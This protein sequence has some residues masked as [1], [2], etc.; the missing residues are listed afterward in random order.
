MLMSPQIVETALADATHRVPLAHAA[1][2][3]IQDGNITIACLNVEETDRFYLASLS[4]ALVAQVI[5]AGIHRFGINLDQPLN[6]I[7]PE[8]RLKGGP[9]TFDRLLN[10]A[11]GLTEGGASNF[12]LSDTLPT[13]ERLIRMA[14]AQQNADGPFAFSYHNGAYV[15]ACLAFERIAGQAAEK[16]I[17]AILSESAGIDNISVIGGDDFIDI[18]PTVQAGDQFLHVP[19]VVGRNSLGSGGLGGSINTMAHW[20]S[21]NLS[22]AMVRSPPT[23]NAVYDKGWLCNQKG[24]PVTRYHTGSGPGYGHYCALLE[25]Q[26]AGIVVLTSSHKTVAAVVAAQVLHKLDLIPRQ[27]VDDALAAEHAVYSA[28]LDLSCLPPCNDPSLSKEYFNS[29]AGLVRIK[30]HNQA[31]QIQFA[32]CPS[33]DGEIVIHPKGDLL[34]RPF[35][36]AVLYD[37][38]QSELLF[39]RPSEQALHIDHY[40]DFTML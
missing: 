35:H 32:D 31:L 27:A 15:A 28:R 8:L 6:S 12:G 7:L 30:Q 21:A 39:L 4:K 37:P 24:A 22:E 19:L 16:L 11:V 17:P 36:K 10:M 23:T 38:D 3:L 40:G 14:F 33:A 2:A 13:T 34:I 25:N 1:V 20:I 26:N 9:A 18:P 5:Q 29:E